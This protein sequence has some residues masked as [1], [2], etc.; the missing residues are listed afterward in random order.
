MTPANITVDLCDVLNGILCP[1]PAY[2]FNG[3]DSLPLPDSLGVENKIPSIAFKIPDLEGFTQLKLVEV[4]TGAVKACVQATLSNGWSAF[5]PAVEW[6]TGGITLAV[7]LFALC[8]SLFSDSPLA[9]RLIDLFHLYQT[10]AASAFLNVNYP[11]VYRSFTLNFAWSMGLLHSNKIQSSINRMRHLTG[12]HMPDSPEESA[13]SLVNRKL[14]P[15]NVADIA[16]LSP[17]MKNLLSKV[18][19][20]DNQ[21]STIP[22]GSVVPTVTPASPNVLQAGLPIYANLMRIATANC[23]MTIFISI[24]ILIAIVGGVFALGYGLLIL[25]EHSPLSERRRELCEEFRFKY[26]S[27]CKSWTIRLVCFAFFTI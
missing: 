23:F 14:S 4:G 16:S 26:C 6:V 25:L 27:F 13:V 9:L 11:S 21:F 8:Q 22:Q 3:S 15:Y 1:L 24:L 17:A 20:S 7:F 18:S 5:Q 10:I 19:D 12:G 2:S